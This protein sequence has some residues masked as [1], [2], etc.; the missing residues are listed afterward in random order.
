[1]PRLLPELP[2]LELDL[3][4]PISR[5]FRLRD[6]I[7]CGDTWHRF[8]AEGKPIDNL[9]RQSE[10]VRAL[11]MLAEAVLD[12][13]VEEFGPIELTYGFASPRLTK[14]I[15]RHICPSL[16]QHAAHE[17]NRAGRPV[18]SRGG[19][20]CDVRVGGL[21]SAEIVRF[22]VGR[23]GFDRVYEYVDA[24]VVHLSVSVEPSRLVVTM[25]QFANGRRGPLR[26]QTMGS[27]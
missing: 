1:M 19:A 25:G 9:P 6:L 20:A 11:G 3:D 26:S 7:E 13:V 21:A 2:P 18:C 15:K 27:D 14:H 12:P 16:D 10:S 22:L 8:A 17:L 4:A 5:H 23:T 24:D